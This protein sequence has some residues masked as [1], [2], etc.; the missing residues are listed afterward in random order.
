ML[1]VHKRANKSA[2]QRFHRFLLSPQYI[3]LIMVLAA[4]AN[5]FSLEVAV[6][7]VYTLLAVYICVFSAELLP[8]MPIVIC[9]YI[10]PSIGNNPGKNEA[11]IF[12]PDRYGIYILCLGVVI[13]GS[14]L[15]R[16]IR[17]RS[18]FFTKKR[19]L[20]PGLLALAAAYLLSG[21]GS[22]AYP[23]SLG[24]N[25]LFALLQSAALI[26]PYF[27]FS[28][29]MEPTRLRKDF[30]AWMGFGVGIVLSIQ[31]L[32]TYLTRDIII[33]G[34]IHR[35]HIYTGWGM[36]N[37]MGGLLAMMIPFAFY[38]ATKYHR[39]WLGTV[40][41][42]GFFV[43]VL[44]T[45][46][47]SS[48]L[49]GLA[50]YLVCVTLMLYY[51]RNRKGNTIA[52]IVFVGCALLALILFHRQI[53]R[54]FSDLLELRFDPNSRDSIYYKGLELFT[55]APVFGSSFFS[56]GFL[57]WDFSEVA[58]F[59]NFFP[60]RWHNTVI[61]LLASCGVVGI[62]AYL[63]H[64]VQTVKLFLRR[65][66]KETTFIACSM[67]VL[68]IASLFDCHFFNIGPTMFYSMALAFAENTMEP[69]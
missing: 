42:S 31:I 29:T 11:S 65:P 26:L 63:L 23:D 51:A 15:Y 64:R 22:Q 34:V 53:L 40:V 9:C 44:L 25:L 62:A 17:D 61:Q 68:L 47:R 2:L 58:G 36:Y 35:S 59:S 39:G 13:L 38:L 28:A 8:L 60:P 14:L 3:A 32:Y 45:C 18:R 20:M 24:K 55:Q 57:P 54:L 7:T 56:P 50:A 27:L 1:S 21:I 6:Y 52:V 46:S 19:Y 41:G 48:I 49:T 33:D 30:F 10:V 16:A 5:L 43:C 67:L 12:S 66:C 4:A 69:R 37:N